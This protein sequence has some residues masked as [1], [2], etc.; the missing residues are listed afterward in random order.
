MGRCVRAL[1]AAS[2]AAVAPPGRRYLSQRSSAIQRIAKLLF[3][4][5]GRGRLPDAKSSGPRPWSDPMVASHVAF[6]PAILV[7]AQQSVFDLAALQSVVVIASTAYHR[8]RERPGTLA[9][10][11][12]SCAKAL[13]LYGALQLAHQPADLS[14]ALRA[15]EFGC[16]ATTL[17][18]FIYTNLDKSAYE[19]W[20]ALGL[21]VVPG[22]WSCAVAWSHL[23]LYTGWL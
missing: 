20:H 16:A 9:K 11:E 13:F 22:V 6:L 23:P 4:P 5:V 8:Q 15:I 12:G 3:D 1:L 17:S 18:M 7:A 19:K 10:F 14:G 21:H 2:A